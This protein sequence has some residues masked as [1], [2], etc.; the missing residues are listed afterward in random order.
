MKK[1][2]ERLLKAFGFHQIGVPKFAN[3]PVHGNIVV[4]LRNEGVVMPIEYSVMLDPWNRYWGV[5]YKEIEHG[6]L[7]W[8]SKQY[9][10][11]VQDIAEV[12]YNGEVWKINFKV[13]ED[14]AK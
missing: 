10:I 12:T 11:E 4:T 8:A 3:Y 2:L 9:N 7:T 6:L 5:P 1:L 13:Q 14:K